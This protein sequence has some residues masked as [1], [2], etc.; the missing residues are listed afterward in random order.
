MLLALEALRMLVPLK[1]SNSRSV[2][3]PEKPLSSWHCPLF[4]ASI[5]HLLV[6]DLLETDKYVPDRSA[7]R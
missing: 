7:R 4:L 2:P 6:N 3:F 1:R 5:H